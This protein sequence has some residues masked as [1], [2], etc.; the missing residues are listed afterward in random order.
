MKFPASPTATQDTNTVRGVADGS[1]IPPV[2]IDGKTSAA[3]H[4]PPTAAAWGAT[5]TDT[6][7]TRGAFSACSNTTAPSASRS[8]RPSSARRTSAPQ[9]LHHGNTTL[10]RHGTTLSPRLPP[11]R[12]RPLPQGD[13]LASRCWRN[14]PPKTIAT[15]TPK[16]GGISTKPASASARQSIRR[17]KDG[18]VFREVLP[19]DAVLLALEHRWRSERKEGNRILHSANFVAAVLGKQSGY[20]P[21]TDC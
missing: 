9:S 1:A 20:C 21:A 4:S 19:A 13:W 17:G 14:A 7:A 12:S 18:G 11:R 5:R 2:D 8:S 10:N 6:R 3:N 15:R 16:A